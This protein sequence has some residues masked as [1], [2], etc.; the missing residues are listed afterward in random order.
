MVMTSYWQKGWMVLEAGYLLGFTV[1]GK[2]AVLLLAAAHWEGLP[3]RA[4]F[5]LWVLSAEVSTMTPS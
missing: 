2:T 4:G 5:T 1:I 3:G